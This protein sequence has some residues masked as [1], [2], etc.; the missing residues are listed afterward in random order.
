MA[1][2]FGAAGMK[3]ESEIPDEYLDLSFD[4]LEYHIR[5]LT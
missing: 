4:S 1:S 3:T 2:T 5:T